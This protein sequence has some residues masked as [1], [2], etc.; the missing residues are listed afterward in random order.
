[1]LSEFKNI[2]GLL[3]AS[4]CTIGQKRNYYIKNSKERS[5]HSRG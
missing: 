3:G 5:R 4:F 2:S 1:M